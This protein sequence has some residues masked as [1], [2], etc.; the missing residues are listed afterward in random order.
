[1]VQL[2]NQHNLLPLL[3]CKVAPPLVTWTLECTDIDRQRKLDQSCRRPRFR[4]KVSDR[5]V[6][7]MVVRF[8][9]DKDLQDRAVEQDGLN[10]LRTDPRAFDQPDAPQRV[11]ML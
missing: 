9:D 4:D 11:E 2:F 3:L 8:R 5:D 6:Q 7:L 10:L 1:M